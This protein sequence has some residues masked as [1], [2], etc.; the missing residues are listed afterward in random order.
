MSIHLTNISVQVIKGSEGDGP[1]LI[2]EMNNKV[3]MIFPSKNISY[4]KGKSLEE[5][6][7]CRIIG[8]GEGIQWPALDIDLSLNGI[9][10]EVL[11]LK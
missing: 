1:Q 6:Q 8:P 9:L 10:K 3:S 5:L 7:D 2:L 4:L 11:G